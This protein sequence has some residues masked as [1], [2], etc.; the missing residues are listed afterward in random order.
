MTSYYTY[1]RKILEQAKTIVAYYYGLY[2]TRKE[3]FDAAKADGIFTCGEFGE[4]V[5]TV[6][7]CYG[8]AIAPLKF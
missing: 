7:T 6:F 5:H 1:E 2:N 4:T 3:A 8:R